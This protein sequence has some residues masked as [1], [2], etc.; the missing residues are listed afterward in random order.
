MSLKDF[1]TI[2]DRRNFV[3]KQI[4]GTFQAISV[5]PQKL[6]EA[7]HKNCE[8]MIG[9]IQL[10]LGI[11]GPLKIERTFAKGNFY[12]PMAT[13]EGA[14]VASVN[15]GCKALISSGITTLVEDVGI[16]RGSIF[17]TG[18]L[19][20]GRDLENWIKQ[21]FVKIAKRAASTSTHLKL[22]SIKTKILGT[23]LFAR[24]SY[25]TS[26][27]MGMNMA[28]IAT[29]KIAEF[30]LREKGYKCIALAGNYDTDKKPS[31]LNF[32]SGRG[33]QVWAE[34]LV[35]KQIVEMVL[36]TTPLDLHKV[37]I[38][39]CLIGGALSGSLGFNAHFANVVAAIFI[40]TGQDPAH[41]VEGSLGVT[42]TEV[43]NGDLYISV[44]L[45]DLILGTVGGGTNLPAQKESLGILGHLKKEE[46]DA[47][48]K[49][50]EIVG[51]AVL[52][53]ELSLLSSIAEGSLSSAHE[54]FGRAKKEYS[55]K[56]ES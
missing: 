44:F 36:K 20:K 7:A 40:A 4:Q 5:Y 26:E 54:K 11:A 33:K 38:D 18:G 55:D 25:H 34:G 2:K 47:S 39:K 28:T 17:E 21:N 49:F 50:A 9:A 29:Q 16:T 56:H 42:S 31:W 45:P 41:V 14:L 3:E 22:M 13:T 6:E 8:N 46:G 1:K 23:R 35:R 15:R 24:F 32:I 51:A 43:I 10:P 37:A 19:A 27:A 12:V 52:A 53:G 30:I 48:L